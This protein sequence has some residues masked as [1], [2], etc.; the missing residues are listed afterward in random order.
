MAPR[1]SLR[2]APAG[3]VSTRPDSP[4]PAAATV[5]LDE[6]YYNLN[7]SDHTLTSMTD[8]A[9]KAWLRVMFAGLAGLVQ[10]RYA[11]LT[12]N[13]KARVDKWR[14]G[15]EP[16]VDTVSPVRYADRNKT[17]LRTKS[18]FAYLAEVLQ[19]S[20]DWYL[21]SASLVGTELSK[22]TG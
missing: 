18:N 3:S 4:V 1:R 20:R 6:F 17:F 16:Q 8:E 5:D 10:K 12:A 22:L 2:R 11:S 7:I 19:N 9:Y 14:T 15:C 21:V 13:R